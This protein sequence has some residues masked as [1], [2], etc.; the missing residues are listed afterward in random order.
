M[1]N[2]IAPDGRE[3]RETLA[4]NLLQQKVVLNGLM[5]RWKD[6][7]DDERDRWRNVADVALT[8]LR[9][10]GYRIVLAAERERE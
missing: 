9:D 1:Y 3:A 10:A 5:F 8:A 7:T 6:L 4:Q 2:G